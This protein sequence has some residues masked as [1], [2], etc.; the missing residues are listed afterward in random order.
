MFNKLFFLVIIDVFLKLVRLSVGSKNEQVLQFLSSWA[1][2]VTDSGILLI[3]DPVCLCFVPFPRI[4]HLMWLD[5][6]DV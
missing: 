1:T 3:G 4:R 2:D 6:I 5:W